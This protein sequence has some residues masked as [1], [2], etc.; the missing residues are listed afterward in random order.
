[1][2]CTLLKA[3]FN[4]DSM[5]SYMETSSL[6]HKTEKIKYLTEFFQRYERY[7][8]SEKVDLYLDSLGKIN[9][10]IGLT[11][12]Y[13]QYDNAHR[14]KKRIGYNLD[15]SYGF[16]DYSPI[17]IYDYNNDTTITIYYNYKFDLSDVNIKIIDT[18]KRLLEDINYNHD[19]T[20]YEDTK[21]IYNDIEHSRLIKVY[22]LNGKLTNDKYGV[23]IKYQ[24]IDSTDSEFIIEER[25]YN[26]RMKLVNANH[27]NL[28][29]HGFS[30]DYAILKRAIKNGEK[31]TSY[32]DEKNRLQFES[33]D[34]VIIKSYYK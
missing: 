23:A 14:I 25:F 30:C 34:I 31:W 9:E 4:I 12:I 17:V 8:S 10:Y 20:Y 2:T 26:K 19:F 15:G 33:D 16:W 7:D 24:Q 27:S 6:W 1:M 5:K 3:Q 22:N 32:Y 29:N 11:A 18:K 13:K 21:Y 28:T